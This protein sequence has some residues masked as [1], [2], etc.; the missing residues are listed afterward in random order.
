MSRI[1]SAPWP[2]KAALG[3]ALVFSAAT[4]L[5]VLAAAIA[6]AGLHQLSGHL[7]PTAVPG[8][9]WY[10]R[11]DP[12]VQRWLKIGALSAGGLTIVMTFAVASNLRRPLHGAARWANEADLRRAGLR[13][14]TGIVLGRKAGRLLVFGGAEHVMLYAPT[15]TG[16]GVGVVIPNLLTWPDSVVVLDVKRENWDATAGFRAAHG[17]SVLLFDPL[18][19]EGRTARYNPLGHIDRGDSIQV[20]DELQRIAAMLFPHPDNTDP[21]WAESARTGFVG[22]GAYLAETPERPFTLG[23]LYAELTKG[24]PRIRLPETIKLRAKEGHPLSAGC[25]RAL[26]DFCGSSENTFAGIRQTLTSR[27]SLW[28][29]PRVCAA[30]EAS[31]F[32]LRTLRQRRQS[33]YLAT[34]PDN[35]IR[36]APLYNLLFQQ[37][38]DLNCRERANPKQHPYQ[39]LVLLDEF[40]RLGHAGVIAKGFAYVA[41][42]GLRLLPVLQSPAQLRAEYGPDVTEEILANCA[43]EIAFAPKELR[44]ANDLSERLGY[45]TVR[46]PSRS[47]PSGLSRGHRSV[48]ESD[49][50]RALMLPQELMQLP[51][52]DLIVLKAGM[53]PVRG[54]KIA[55]YRERA[56]NDRV[57]PP[58]RLPSRPASTA[59]F[60][61]AEETPAPPAKAQPSDPLTLDLIVPMLEAEGLEP[62]P[63]EGASVE[64]VEAWVERYIDATVS[65]PV[66]EP[67]HGR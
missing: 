10:F 7:D 23:A 40:A 21:F 17:Q 39:V 29:N 4:V 13:A 8:W 26:T 62:L 30:T 38:V 9:F 36:V 44:L 59:T 67:A 25:V 65:Q 50:R 42:Y 45:T 56:F 53:P 20:L 31:D 15:R 57:H 16:K 58:P 41:G 3:A 6:L 12:Q 46:S 63:P 19:P 54:R 18:D 1:A 60:D 11:G 35:L 47:R 49:Q 66:M 5:T 51:P 64:A 24:D 22:V 61:I 55:Y 37:L 28:L 14:K 52:D 48:S 32:D 2:L 34:S 33:L 43:V 27:L